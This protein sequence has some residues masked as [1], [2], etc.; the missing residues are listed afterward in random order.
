MGISGER[1]FTPS[2]MIDE[3]IFRGS[4]EPKPVK[5]SK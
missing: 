3:I 4:E 1:D 5:F 2:T